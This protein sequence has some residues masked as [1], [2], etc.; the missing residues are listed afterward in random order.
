MQIQ[1]CKGSII[2]VC[3]SIKARPT[4]YAFRDDIDKQLI[5][6]ETQDIITKTDSK[7]WGTT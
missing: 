5:E 6:L 7:E 1:K 4:P 2:E 3:K